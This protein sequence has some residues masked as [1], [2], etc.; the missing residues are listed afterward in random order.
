VSVLQIHR[1]A[2]EYGQ[3]LATGM[4]KTLGF[5][6]VDAMIGLRDPL[7]M[8]VLRVP[9]AEVERSLAPLFARKASMA[10]CRHVRPDA[11]DVAD[12]LSAARR[13]RLPLR[14]MVEP[15]FQAAPCLLMDDTGVLTEETVVRTFSILKATDLLSHSRSVLGAYI[16]GR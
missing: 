9:W 2:R 8:L 13:A 10:A 15:L 1:H 7:A 11:A 4:A 6:P 14:L 3:S 5:S 16:S 12:G